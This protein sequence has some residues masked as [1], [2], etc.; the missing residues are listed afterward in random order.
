MLRVQGLIAAHARV[1]N[2]FSMRNNRLHHVSSYAKPQKGTRANPNVHFDSARCWVAKHS[3]AQVTMI[4]QQ[5]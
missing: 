5:G 3:D 4:N 1:A 2:I